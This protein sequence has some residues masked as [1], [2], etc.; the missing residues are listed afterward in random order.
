MN[1]VGDI[2]LGEFSPRRPP[3]EKFETNTLIRRLE[4]WES[5]LPKKVQMN[6][7][8]GYTKGSFW[9]CMLQTSY[10]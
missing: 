1:L 8:E 6:A 4:E 9:G 7:H 10:Q 5:E 3:L 2:L